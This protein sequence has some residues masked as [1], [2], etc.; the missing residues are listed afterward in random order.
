MNWDNHTINIAI[1]GVGAMGCLFGARLT[2]HADVTLIGRWPEQLDALR[3][4]PLRVI[5]ADGSVEDIRLRATNDPRA[6]GTADVALILTKAPKTD[7]AGRDAA[8]ILAPDG[9]AITLQNG[10]GNLEALARQVGVARASLGVTTQGAAMEG[11]GRLRFGGPGL[12]TLATRPEIAARVRALGDVL[13]RAG[14]PTSIADDVTGLVWGKL[15][16]NAGINPLTAL[17][18]VPN[19]A[20]LDSAWALG[21]LRAAANEVAAVAAAQRIEL[22][23][24]DAAARAE[25]VAR[26]TARNRSSMLQDVLRG[27]ETEIE[28]ICGAVARAGDAAGVPTPANRLLHELVKALEASYPARVE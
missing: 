1:F 13:E 20:L 7:A 23:F 5:A 8:A 6:V 28:A 18:R 2:P 26:L 24:D 16:V 12:T 3:R 27:T 4:G 9:L 10:I 22:P 15:A 17:L 21:I 14:M 25:E 11:P 19:G